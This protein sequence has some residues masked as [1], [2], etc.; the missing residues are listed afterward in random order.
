MYSRVL[1]LIFLTLLNV[2]LRAQ[3]SASFLQS[4]K[5]VQVIVNGVWDAPPVMAMGGGNTVQISFDDLQ[6][7]YVR[8]TYRISHCDASSRVTTWMD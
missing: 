2:P 3:Q 6:H 1:L 7:D 8:Y 4:I 5:T